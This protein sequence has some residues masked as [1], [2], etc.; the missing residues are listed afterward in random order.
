MQ[1]RT[2]L[3]V[4]LF[5]AISGTI[6]NVYA[7]DPGFYL[8]LMAGPATND[9]STT[10]AQVE[11]SA[12]TTT[13]TPKS[14][15]FGSRIY[16]GYDI[17]KYAGVEAGLTYFSTVKYDTKD[18]DVCSTPN[19]S[20]RDFDAVAKAMLPLGKFSAFGKAGVAITYTN[21]SG[22]LNP[23]LSKTCGENT[24]ETGYRATYSLG[25]SY[26]LS[27]NWVADLSWTRVAVGGVINNMDLY[28]IGFSYH[29]VNIYC[30][31]FLCD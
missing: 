21:T 7:V 5:A 22:A 2:C 29:F 10:Q 8:G 19:A 31:Q 30:G 24:Y 14:S 3:R 12:E 18:V 16:M 27:Q 13:A 26:D 20:V 11:G 9:G 4:M 28:A 6:S 23:D 15:Q 25:V 17:N 1:F